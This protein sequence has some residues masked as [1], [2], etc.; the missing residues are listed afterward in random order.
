[1]AGLIPSTAAHAPVV[2]QLQSELRASQENELILRENLADL[3]LALEDKGWDQISSAVQRDFSPE[4]RKALARICRHMAI[5]NPLLKRG[6]QIR[7][8]YVWGQGVQVRARAAGEEQAQDVNAVVQ[9]FLDAN[10]TTFSGDEAH[11]QLERGA[12]TEG[13]VY[14]ACFTSP[15]TGAVRIRTALADEVVDVITNPDDR[16]EPWYYVREVPQ[17]IVEK[18]YQRGATRTRNQIARV[19]HPALGYRPQVRPQTLDGMPIRW[20]APIKHVKVNPVAGWRFGIP[21]VYASLAWARAYKDFLV[22]WAQLTHSLSL[23]AWQATGG[24]TS[25]AQ[26][27]AQGI[28]AANGGNG[29]G[30]GGIPPIGGGQAGQAAVGTPDVR[31]EAVSKSG[32]TIDAD[33]GKPLAGMAAAGLGLPVTMLLADPGVTGARAVAET[34]DLPTILEMGMRRLLWQAAFTEVIE[35]VVDQAAIAPRGPLR[36]AMSRDEWGRLQVK[37]TGDVEKTLDWDWPPLVD[38]D[39]VELVKAI[40]A[41]AETTIGRAVPVVLLRLLLNALG[42]KDVD[43][44]LEQVTDDE[45][46]L[47]D[48]DL[49]AAQAAVDDERRRRAA[50]ADPVGPAGDPDDEDA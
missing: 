19:A 26:K 38:V 40:T 44:V 47:I 50:G 39:P 4:A 21:D 37:L 20:D 49:V 3:Q 10:K 11:D 41:S 2:E 1:M 43:E 9:G 16:D 18:G 27:V 28:A 24:T 15:M 14:I 25:K 35:Y 12:A 42:V 23:I 30:V 31:L 34:L 45:G 48:P 7:I 46:R 6:M 32:A 22:D 29:P 8:G 13:N 17:R 5:A 36:G 33:S